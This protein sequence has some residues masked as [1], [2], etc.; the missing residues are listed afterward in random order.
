MEQN[1]KELDN[2]ELRSE[3][4]RNII[5]K[6]PPRLV[7]LG[8]VVITIIIIALA[9]AFYLVLHLHCLSKKL[10]SSNRILLLD[11]QRIF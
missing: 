9:V 6:V 5:G 10:F 11:S 2:I 7:S 1:E 4:V 3:K 8:T